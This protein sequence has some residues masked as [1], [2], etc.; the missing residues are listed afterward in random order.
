MSNFFI[1]NKY[2]ALECMVQRKISVN[3]KVLIKLSQQEI[4]DI[5]GFAKTKGNDIVCVLKQNGYLTQLSS[6]GSMH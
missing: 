1:N 2:E 6:R 4:V 5:L 3:D